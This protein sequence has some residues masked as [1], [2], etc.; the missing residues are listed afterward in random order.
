MEDMVRKEAFYTLLDSGEYSSDR[1][2][3]ALAKHQEWDARDRAFYTALVET[4]LENQT[5]IDAI[6]SAYS[7][8]RLAKL[9][10]VVR[11]AIELALAQV[12]YMNRVPDSAACNES[13]KLVKLGGEGRYTGFANGL[14]RNIIRNKINIEARIVTRNFSARLLRVK[15]ESSA[16]ARERPEYAW[17]VLDPRLA[18]YEYF[19]N[20]SLTYSYPAWLVEHFERSYD[21]AEKI[22]KGLR[23]EKNSGAFCNTGAGA[24]I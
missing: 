8:T 2:D 22:L 11:A 24:H 4:T 14:I 1:M 15:T 9:R 5:T 13:V 6:I 19:F 7:R 16:T 18:S 21:G 23:S 17:K 20:L 10:P 3:A 12:F